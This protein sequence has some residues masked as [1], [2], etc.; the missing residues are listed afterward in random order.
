MKPFFSIIIPLYNKAKFIKETLQ[1]VLDQDFFDFEVIVVDDGSTDDSVAIVTHF[2]DTRIILIKQKNTGVSA[3]RNNGISIAKGAHIALIDA[4]DYWYTNHLTAL[5][6]QIKQFPNAGLYCNNYE[7]YLDK[8][9]KRNAQFNFSYNTDCLIVRDFFRASIINSVAWTSAVAFPKDKFNAVGGFDE[10]LDT[11]EDLDLW[12]KLALRYAVSFNPCLT[13]SYKY[14][15]HNSLTKKETNAVRLNFINSYTSE[16]DSNAALKH[17]L[18]INR[19]AL[20][21]R[22]KILKEYGLYKTAKQ[23]ILLSN[24]NFKQKLLLNTPRALLITLKKVH[25]ALIKNNIYLSAF[26]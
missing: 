3:A 16:E 24:L 21:I 10:D 1:S 12:I 18:D 14:Y 8:N 15:I 13:M 22:C 25:A 11:S 5:I 26:K 7:I 2:N 23:Q 17:Y 6:N 9:T 20:A 19:Y 4:D